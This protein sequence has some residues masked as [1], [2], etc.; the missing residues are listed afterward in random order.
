[1][2]ANALRRNFV[3]LLAL[4]TTRVLAAE[5]AP[6]TTAHVV[7]HETHVGIYVTEG[8]RLSVSGGQE[9]GDRRFVSD[10]T[11][12]PARVGVKFGYSVKLEGPCGWT[13]PI[14]RVSRYPAPGLVTDD[15]V[16]YRT[17]ASYMLVDGCAADWGAGFSFDTT[18]ELLVGRWTFELWNGDERIYLRSFDVVPDDGRTILGSTR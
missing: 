14:R 2:T 11:I 9:V 4:V 10:S 7:A 6:T 16:R 12:V 3:M 1:M 15:G 17:A 5:A 13:I 8:A 18:D